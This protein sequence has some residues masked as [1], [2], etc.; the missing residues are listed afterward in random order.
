MSG[1][2]IESLIIFF[3]IIFILGFFSYRLYLIA[4]RFLPKKLKIK[5]AVKNFRGTAFIFVVCG[6]AFLYFPYFAFYYS[7]TNF[8]PGHLGEVQW[9]LFETVVFF[10]IIFLLIRR[11]F[12]TDLKNTLIMTVASFVMNLY[13]WFLFLISILQSPYL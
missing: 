10:S 8:I 4:F 5:P 7:W 11:L 12:K 6:L 2:P 1:F 9:I 13:V 3:S